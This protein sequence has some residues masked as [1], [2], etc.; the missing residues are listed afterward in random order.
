MQRSL[1]WNVTLS[2][3]GDDRCIIRTQSFNRRVMGVCSANTS[4]PI[5]PR[6]THNQ[7]HKHREVVK[8]AGTGRKDAFSERLLFSALAEHPEGLKSQLG[9]NLGPIANPP[10]FSFPD[11]VGREC[12]RP[13]PPA[14]TV[15]PHTT[16]DP[17]IM[18]LTA[19][20]RGCGR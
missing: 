14:P 12:F 20:G 11:E 16:C 6:R 4:R 18:R 15:H 7:T 8:Q 17:S 10:T 3:N 13:T 9:T 5:T 2:Q 19:Y 1:D